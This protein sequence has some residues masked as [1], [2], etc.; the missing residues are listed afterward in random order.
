MFL[1]IHPPSQ[2]AISTKRTEKGTKRREHFLD[3]A[4]EKHGTKLVRDTKVLLRILVLYLPLPLFWALFDQQGSRWT[5]QATKMDGD[6]G[7]YTFKPDQMHV[8]NPLLVLAIVPL[9]NKVVYPI[10]AK[11]GINTSLRKL[12]LGGMLA[13]LAFVLSGIVELEL[14]KSN[15]IL[16]NANHGQIRLFNGFPCEYN[17]RSNIS[18]VNNVEL[19]ALEAYQVLQLRLS[20]NERFE[21]KFYQINGK[22]TEHCPKAFT[23]YTY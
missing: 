5:F 3:Y 15:P 20:S 22:E 6:F 9:M 14:D 1:L 18:V 16:P 21:L 4:I 10:I 13:A 17:I 2:T 11:I 12:T 23:R 8:L 19:G 7:I